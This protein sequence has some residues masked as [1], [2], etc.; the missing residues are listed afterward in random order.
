M[1]M[2]RRS[3][4][5]LGVLL[6][7]VASLQAPLAHEHPDDPE[8]HHAK[9]FVHGHFGGHFEHWD[10]PE[11]HDVHQTDAVLDHDDSEEPTVWLSWFPS[12][13]PRVDLVQAVISTATEFAP[14][15]VRLGTSPDFSPQA[16]SPPRRT[17]LPSRAPP[18]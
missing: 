16:H 4:Y 13:Q 14:E 17:L 2:F 9:G 7:I 5:G 15:I 6:L 11:S 18:A 8:H 3:Y 1:E 10:H 12:A